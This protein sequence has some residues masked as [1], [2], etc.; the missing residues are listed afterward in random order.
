MI[1]FVSWSFGQPP[2]AEVVMLEEKIEVKEGKLTS[3]YFVEIKINNRFGDKYAEVQIPNSGTSS[4]VKIK[5][6]LLNSNR[7]RLQKLRKKDIETS[8]LIT[9]FSLYEDH[10]VSEFEFKH[11]DYPYYI[12]YSYKQIAKEFLHITN[13]TPVLYFDIPTR[14]ALLTITTNTNLPLNIYQNMLE[15]QQTIDNEKVTYKW[16][17]NYDRQISNEAFTPSLDKIVP[18]VKVSPVKF[19]FEE[20]GNFESW[21]G[22]GEWQLRIMND[23]EE[24]TKEEKDKIDELIRNKESKLRKL[25]VL[26]HYMQDNTRYVNISIGT[27]GLVPYPASYVC[28]NRYGDCKALTNYFEAVLKYAGIDSFYSN[29]YAGSQINKI[30]KS[31]LGSQFNHIILM[32]PMRKDTVWLDCT[33]SGPFNYLGTFTQNRNAFVLKPED[34]HFVKTPALSPSDVM[35]ERTAEVYYRNSGKADAKISKRLRGEKFEMLTSIGNQ[36]SKR[37]RKEYVIDYFVETGMEL[38]SYSIYQQ[39]RDSLFIDLIYQT[40]SDQIYEK[41]GEDLLVKTFSF[42]LPY[43]K[44]THLRELPLN[45]PF[46]IHKR[47]SLVFELPAELKSNREI[48]NEDIDNQ[49]GKFSKQVYQKQNKLFVIKSLLI[50]GIEADLADYAGFHDFIE[51]VRTSENKNTFLI[52]KN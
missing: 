21:S 24:L 41:V 36:V 45:I 8:S 22:F 34:S 6:E 3:E 7:E 23:L 9:G 29:V 51:Q 52:N 38:K 16:T 32:V 18:Y 19:E 5:G 12:R 15:H 4:T 43:F 50:N 47:D 28:K 11:N 33:S 31:F 1:L 26:Y 35:D 42:D 25:K 39:D 40:H 17:A 48:V 44:K 49:Y 27:G 10:T 46:P 14:S 37:N 20:Y 30:E 2:K 13:W